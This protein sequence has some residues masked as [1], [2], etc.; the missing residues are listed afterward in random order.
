MITCR[1]ELKDG[2]A[3]T[4]E[5]SVHVLVKIKSIRAEQKNLTLAYGQTEQISWTVLPE[6]ALIQELDWA[7]SNEATAIVNAEGKVTGNVPGKAVIIGTAKDGSKKAVR[8]DVTVSGDDVPPPL[9]ILIEK[10]NIIK[11]KDSE[12]ANVY[13]I[14][15]T[16]E[17]V[18][19][20]VC[21]FSFYN[22]DGEQVYLHLPDNGGMAWNWN[23]ARYANPVL[24]RD[25]LITYVDTAEYQGETDIENVRAAISGYYL[26]DGTYIR[27][28]D[29]QLYWFDMKNKYEPRLPVTE[30]TEPAGKLYDR[31]AECKFG[32]SSMDLFSDYCRDVDSN[33]EP[34]LFVNKIEE[35]SVAERAGLQL[36]DVIYGIDELLWKDEPNITV[37]A[38]SRLLD[39]QAVTVR[40]CRNGEKMDIVIRPEDTGWP[41]E[42]AP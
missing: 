15:N 20:V 29:S 25:K 7:S 8:I 36:H 18:R 26:E 3:L 13:A 22:R 37:Y 40:I 32:F 30:Y 27:I 33:P 23:G 19:T 5:V 38:K 16:G 31:T 42:A 2:P 10:I 1:A 35:G 39:G 21:Q 28:P 12:R 11:K 41:T 4:A 6:N 9:K 24:N 14:N 17:S 34:G